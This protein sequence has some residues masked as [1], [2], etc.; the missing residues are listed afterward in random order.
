MTETIVNYQAI[1][2]A[3]TPILSDQVGDETGETVLALLDETV[4][5]Y[6][7]EL[8]AEDAVVGESEVAVNETAVTEALDYLASVREDLQKSHTA[9]TDRIDETIAH[10]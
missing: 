8:V 7:D 9:D 1:R 4:A 2:D 6:A 3:L 10:F 5:E